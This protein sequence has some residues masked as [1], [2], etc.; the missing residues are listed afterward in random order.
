MSSFGEAWNIVEHRGTAGIEA[1]CLIARQMM[2]ISSN[3]WF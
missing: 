3:R 1:I 2:G